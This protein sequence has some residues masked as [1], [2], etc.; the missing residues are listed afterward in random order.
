MAKGIISL[1][2]NA[3]ATKIAELVG[4]QFRGALEEDRRIRRQE[5]FEDRQYEKRQNG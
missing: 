5:N 4:Q 3:L 2:D 1:A